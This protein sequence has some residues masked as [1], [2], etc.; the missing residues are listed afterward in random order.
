MGRPPTP[1]KLPAQ[2]ENQKDPDDDYDRLQISLF[3]GLGVNP[4]YFEK[5]ETIVQFRCYIK[6]AK[7]KEVFMFKRKLSLHS[8]SGAPGKWISIQKLLNPKNKL[9][10][11]Q[12]LII[13]ALVRTKIYF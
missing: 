9:V 3:Q 12:K 5:F 1:Y 8:L 2:D 13:V 4:N 10:N 11:N 6:N 7:D